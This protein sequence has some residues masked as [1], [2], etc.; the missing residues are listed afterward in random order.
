MDVD[1]ERGGQPFK[2]GYVEFASRTPAFYFSRFTLVLLGCAGVFGYVAGSELWGPSAEVVSTLRQAI[3]NYGIEPDIIG[4]NEVPQ[5]M[6]VDLDRTERSIQRSGKTYRSYWER[7]THGSKGTLHVRTTINAVTPKSPRCDDNGLIDSIHYT[8]TWTGG[9][10]TLQLSTQSAFVPESEMSGEGSNQDANPL[11]ARIVRLETN[12]NEIWN[13]FAMWQS[14]SNLLH[15]YSC[16]FT[17][18][19][20]LTYHIAHHSCCIREMLRATIPYGMMKIALSLAC[21]TNQTCSRK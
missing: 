5:E 13:Y 16:Y 7:G 11:E 2:T 8:S 6:E 12:V 20:I 18:P 3:T 1:G 9:A 14:Y 17:Y 4:P 15:E 10:M 21:F 19:A